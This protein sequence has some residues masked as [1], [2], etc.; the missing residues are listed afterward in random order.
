MKKSVLALLILSAL[1]GAKASAAPADVKI[2]FIDT[3]AVLQDYSKAQDAVKK[4]GVSESKLRQ[5]ILDKK[6][7]I[8]KARANN[9][10]ET[11]IQMLLEKFKLEIEPE[12]KRLEEESARRSKEIEADLNEAIEDVAKDNKIDFVLARQALLYGGEDLGSKVTDKLR[13]KK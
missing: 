5:K 12:A 10:S 4:L 2:G 3:V 8:T 6:E 11:K 7:A 13:K 1:F 9:E